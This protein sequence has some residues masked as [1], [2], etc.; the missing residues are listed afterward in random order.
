MSEVRRWSRWRPV[1][2]VLLLIALVAFVG[3]YHF[4]YGSQVSPQKL[5]K[6]SWSLSETIINVDEVGHL[7]LI[8][9]RS[10]YPLFLQA[11]EHAR[12]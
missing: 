5:S 8:V 10:K 4:I 9:A 12:E 6:V 7:P 1:V 3:N 11:L 2:L